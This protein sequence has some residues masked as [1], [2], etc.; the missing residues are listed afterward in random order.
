MIDAAGLRLDSTAGLCR[1]SKTEASHAMPCPPAL[2]LP[3]P[4]QVHDPA[5]TKHGQRAP[6]FAEW[7]S[8]YMTLLFFVPWDRVADGVG[9][10]YAVSKRSHSQP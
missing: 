6:L 10:G 7:P 9:G 5:G 2:T 8:S 4:C 3:S 1:V